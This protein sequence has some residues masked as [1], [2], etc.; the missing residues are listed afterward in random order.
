MGG[1]SIAGASAAS[2]GGDAD[3]LVVE[4]AD[5][6]AARGSATGALKTGATVCGGASSAFTAAVLLPDSVRRGGRAAGWAAAGSASSIPNRDDGLMLA[7]NPRLRRR[8]GSRRA[9]RGRRRHWAAL[10]DLIFRGWSGSHLRH[11][12][13]CGRGSRAAE[14]LHA[15]REEIAQLAR[16]HQRRRRQHRHPALGPNPV[17]GRESNLYSAEVKTPLPQSTTVSQYR[18]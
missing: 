3:A 18:S 13:R 1:R 12:R 14:I 6:G 9:S 11:A 7:G 15:C 4:A 5:G 2:A 16:Q 10:F 8:D 17:H